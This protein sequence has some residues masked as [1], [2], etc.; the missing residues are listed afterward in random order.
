MR[1]RVARRDRRF[2][3]VDD[4]DAPEILRGHLAPVDAAPAHGE[5]HRT[6]VAT[7]SFAVG[8]ILTGALDAPVDFDQDHDEWV[9][10][11]SGR[12]TLELD[13]R[14]HELV[15]GDWLFLPARRRHR[16]VGAEPGTR[17]L[18][19]TGRR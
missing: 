11:I 16:L 5:Q 14:R 13:D 3:V 2:V 17:W 15:A 8:E 10:V 19:V 6:L 18:T 7:R 1:P 4:H 12:A 9:L